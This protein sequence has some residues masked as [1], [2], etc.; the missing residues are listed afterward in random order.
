MFGHH[1]DV[2]AQDQQADASVPLPESTIDALTNAPATSSE[3]DSPAPVASAPAMDEP[4]EA[5]P[6]TAVSAPQTFAAP[7]HSVDGI[8]AAPPQPAG[9]SSFSSYMSAPSVVTPAAP[10]PLASASFSP[11]AQDVAA[12]PLSETPAEND[13]DAADTSTP[14][15]KPVSASI[16]PEE[17]L[18]IKQEALQSLSPLVGKL[19]VDPEEKFRT[20]MMLIQASDDHSKLAEAYEVAKTITDEKARAQALL[21]VV[22][23]INYFTSKKK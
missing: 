4:V 23:E 9:A 6:D 17:L 7:T 21:D 15:V 18:T 12:A 10:E 11:A 19:D 16:T 2:I 22:N 8:V 5:V 13:T 3:T 1:N 20:L 14:T